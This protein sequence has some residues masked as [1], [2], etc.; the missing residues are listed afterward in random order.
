MYITFHSLLSDD[1]AWATQKQKLTTK[2]LHHST[3]QKEVRWALAEYPLKIYLLYNIIAGL[4]MDIAVS[5]FVLWKNVVVLCI[6]CK[7]LTTKRHRTSEGN[8]C[9][10][11]H[12]LKMYTISQSH[13]I[14]PRVIASNNVSSYIVTENSFTIL[15]TVCICM[16]DLSFGF[17]SAN[18]C[19]CGLFFRAN[20]RFSSYRVFGLLDRWRWSIS[21]RSSFTLFRLDINW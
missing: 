18:F 21:M 16:Q 20:I 15:L 13:H 6:L 2:K 1:I 11:C 12:S 14:L 8:K 9:I 17:I 5:V 19:C 10:L 3:V 7:R 4:S